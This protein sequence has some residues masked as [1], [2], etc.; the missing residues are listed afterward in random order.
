MKHLVSCII[1]LL[2]SEEKKR[3]KYPGRKILNILV[4]FQ[5]KI[6]RTVTRVKKEIE[7]WEQ[8]FTFLH[9]LCAPTVTDQKNDKGIA[10]KIYQKQKLGIATIKF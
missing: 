8:E 9:N 1:W 10:K 2:H 3:S 7:C 4:P 6:A 5:T